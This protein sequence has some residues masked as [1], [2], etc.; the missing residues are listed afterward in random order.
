MLGGTFSV[1]DIFGR[2]FLHPIFI[3][4]PTMEIHKNLTPRGVFLVVADKKGFKKEHK[5]LVLDY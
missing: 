3:S 4:Q 1:L 5:F 2:K